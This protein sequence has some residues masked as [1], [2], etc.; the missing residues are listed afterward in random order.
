MPARHQDREWGSHRRNLQTTAVANLE[1]DRGC[2]KIA[3]V[4]LSDLAHEGCLQTMHHSTTDHNGTFYSKYEAF[5]KSGCWATGEPSR[6]TVTIVAL[7][8][9]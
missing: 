8:I 5:H 7:P 1:N 6:V 4:L 3:S 9:T 2:P